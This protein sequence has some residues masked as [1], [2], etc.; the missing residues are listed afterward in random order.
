[1][2]LELKNARRVWGPFF[3]QAQLICTAAGR[4]SVSDEVYVHMVA[5]SWPGTLKLFKELRPRFQSIALHI[6]QWKRKPM[7]YAHDASII[8]HQLSNTPRGEIFS[9]PIA[10]TNTWNRYV[11][12]VTRGGRIEYL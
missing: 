9:T 10:S 1:M 8:G 2:G 11:D 6:G 4:V 7:A 12:R 5:V 3:A